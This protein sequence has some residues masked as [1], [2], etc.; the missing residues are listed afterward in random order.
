M[1]GAEAHP[2]PVQ[3]FCCVGVSVGLVPDR[4]LL[5]P[6]ATS[7]GWPGEVGTLGSAGKERPTTIVASA[8]SSN[9]GP[10]GTAGGLVRGGRVFAGGFIKGGRVCAGGLVREAGSAR[11]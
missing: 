10:C 11:T 3:Y 4:L 9:A 7:T 5:G 1:G 8:F 2:Q 6:F